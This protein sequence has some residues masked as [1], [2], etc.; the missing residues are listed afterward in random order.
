MYAFFPRASLLI[1]TCRQKHIREVELENALKL[2][3]DA[4]KLH[5]LGS[6]DAAAI[7]YESLLSLEVL[8]EVLRKVCDLSHL[9]LNVRMIRVQM[10][11]G[12]SNLG[13]FQMYILVLLYFHTSSSKTMVHYS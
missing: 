1:D 10:L 5:S 12:M 4:L 6:F 7:A 2:Y 13:P 8:Q 11:A 3:Q 9:R